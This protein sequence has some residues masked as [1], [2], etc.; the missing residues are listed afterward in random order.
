MKF[1]KKYIQEVFRGKHDPMNDKKLMK[2]VEREMRR[3]G[4]LL[5]GEEITE[6]IDY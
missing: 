1:T 3:S 2:E 6:G 5:E 4:Q